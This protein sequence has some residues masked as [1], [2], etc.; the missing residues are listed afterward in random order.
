MD[1]DKKYSL[2]QL[3]SAWGAGMYSASENDD[4]SKENILASIEEFEKKIKNLL[5]NVLLSIGGCSEEDI[6]KMKN[7]DSTAD[8]ILSLHDKYPQSNTQ[9]DNILQALWNLNEF[10]SNLRIEYGKKI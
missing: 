7:Y 4:Y 8:I 6:L 5:T 10:I 9:I 2:E 1:N 3:R